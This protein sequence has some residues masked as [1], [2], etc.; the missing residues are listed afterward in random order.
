ME[1]FACAI[2]F[3][4]VRM[5]HIVLKL[6]AAYVPQPFVFAV[7]EYTADDHR[8]QLGRKKLYVLLRRV[9]GN[10]H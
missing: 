8:S 1:V 2:D 9:N 5:Q 6:T 7:D 10:I 4:D 3:C